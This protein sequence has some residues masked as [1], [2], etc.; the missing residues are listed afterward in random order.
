MGLT[1]TNNVL[2]KEEVKRMEEKKKK[3]MHVLSLVWLYKRKKKK[4]EK[5]EEEECGG[6]MF[7]PW[8]PLY[9]YQPNLGRN[10]RK[11]EQ[12]FYWVHHFI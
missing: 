5:K 8:D 7:F 10:G 2:G 6:V 1:N 3:R 11:G 4:K 12:N 9:C